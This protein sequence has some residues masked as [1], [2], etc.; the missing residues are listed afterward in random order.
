ML[1]GCEIFFLCS[2]ALSRDITPRRSTKTTGLADL[3]L[4]LQHVASILI[5]VVIDPRPVQML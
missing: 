1:A 4:L 2:V 5:E 3:A